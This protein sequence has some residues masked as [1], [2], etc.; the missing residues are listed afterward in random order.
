MKCALCLVSLLLCLSAVFSYAITENHLAKRASLYFPGKKLYHIKK[1]KQGR[2]IKH[3]FEYISLYNGQLYAEDD[4][5][6]ETYI[7]NLVNF[8][9]NECKNYS[10][11]NLTDVYL[12]ND[13]EKQVKEL[14]KD[15]YLGK[16]KN[17]EVTVHFTIDNKCKVSSKFSYYKYEIH[18]HRGK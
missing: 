1:D 14:F 5:E 15:K 11:R 10:E 3:A 4:N 16:N 9:K 17:S 8:N 18:H 2:N 6:K 12:T 13:K 7:F